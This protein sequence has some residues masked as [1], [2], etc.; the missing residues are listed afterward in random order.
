MLELVL[1]L[2]LEQV[3]GLLQIWAPSLTHLLD[4]HLEKAF[5]TWFLEHK[6]S[7]MKRTY[8]T[9]LTVGQAPCTVRSSLK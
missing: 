9:P 8:L 7:Q 3:H 2:V 1:E 4:T 5:D 6:Q